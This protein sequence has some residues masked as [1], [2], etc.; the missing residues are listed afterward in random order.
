MMIYK[1]ITI[2]IL[3]VFLIYFIYDNIYKNIEPFDPVDLISLVSVGGLTSTGIQV[4]KERAAKLLIEEAGAKGTEM[5]TDDSPKNFTIPC[6]GNAPGSNSQLVSIG[7]S[8]LEGVSL[9]IAENATIGEHIGTHPSIDNA[10][11]HHTS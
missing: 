11:N 3:I 2:F 5:A 7:C 4:A 8:L 9:A 6:M 10:I 1:K